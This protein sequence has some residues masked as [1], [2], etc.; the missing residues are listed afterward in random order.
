VARSSAGP[1]V[2]LLSVAQRAF[3]SG[4]FGCLG[5]GVGAMLAFV[6]TFVV[7]RPQAVALI[8]RVSI[9]PLPIVINVQGATLVPE[10]V[11][12]V[13]PVEVFVTTEQRPEAVR[14][15]QVKLASRQPLFVFVRS[16]QGKSTTVTVRVTLPSGE[17]TTLGSTFVTDP[18]GKAVCIGALSDIA[19]LEGTVRI[20]ALAGTTVVGST[21]LT[22]VP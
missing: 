5:A 3:V 16:P 11:V 19:G 8:R 20:E 21:V 15:T 13:T 9:P 6:T 14:V 10:T 12:T 17:V 7:L 22:V 18:T 1:A 2:G 4:C